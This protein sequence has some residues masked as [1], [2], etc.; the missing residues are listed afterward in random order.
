[1]NVATWMCFISKFVGPFTTSAMP[2][3]DT[4]FPPGKERRRFFIRGR[5]VG[6][7]APDLKI[8]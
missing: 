2:R 1:M 4:H 8:V 7:R 6:I 3:A 5:F